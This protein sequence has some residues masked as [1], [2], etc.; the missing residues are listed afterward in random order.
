[1]SIDQRLFSPAVVEPKS[2]R[3][4]KETLRILLCAKLFVL[5]GIALL[6]A[7]AIVRLI[8]HIAKPAGQY[9]LS[10]V[11]ALAL[12]YLVIAAQAGVYS[13]RAL[14]NPRDGMERMLSSLAYALFVVLSVAFFLKSSEHISRL[15][16]GASA[17]TAL[18]L[19]L[20]V[21]WLFAGHSRKVTGGQF[22]DQLLIL[23]GAP[24]PAD[25]GEAQIA[26]AGILHITPDV[27]DPQAMNR[28]GM[29]AKPFDRVIIATVPERRESW[30]Q[31]LKG[32]HVDGEILLEGNSAVG[33]I[34]L[35]S[36]ADR[37]T[38]LVS[39]KPLNLP[40]RA[41][42]RALDLSVTIPLLIAL[43]PLFAIVALAI[44]LDSTGPVLFRQQRVGRGNRLFR[45]LKFRSMRHER[46]DPDGNL[47]ARRDDDRITRIGRFIRAT[48]IDEL[49]QLINVLLGDMSLV[50]P[51]PHALG[52]LAG[53]RLFWEVDQTYWH[54]HQLKPGITGLA[55]V[56]GHRGATHDDRALINRLQ[57]DMEYAENWSLWRDLSILLHT[58]RVLLHRNA[59]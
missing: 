51:R 22:Y 5:D 41:Q 13:A 35:R 59:F 37:T 38:I 30:A 7:M 29:L 12:V 50:G 55:Q 14:S 56:R 54:R 8:L 24:P 46:C 32:A 43:L 20:G 44:K 16:L 52:S 26:D 31:A 18:P 36:F 33:A 58:F 21:R 42:K 17:A 2:G 11:I 57:A 53:D 19:M 9:S 27:T 1:M 40:A 47:S 34:G 4:A 10:P 28:F 6:A 39:R 45:M 3:F 48:S 49:P 23:D 15:L 25:A